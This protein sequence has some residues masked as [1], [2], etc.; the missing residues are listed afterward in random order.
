MPTFR[1]MFFQMAALVAA[2]FVCAA[3][4]AIAQPAQ[5]SGVGPCRQAA[6]IILGMLDAK[7]DDTADYRHAYDGLTQTCGPAGMPSAQPPSPREECVKL[8]VAVLDVIEENKINTQAFV[9]ART[10]FA[11]SCAPR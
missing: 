9:H 11:M 6:L 5:R 10:R 4:V 7:E 8:A 2:I 3:Q 1:H